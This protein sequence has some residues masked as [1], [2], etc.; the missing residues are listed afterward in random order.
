M[1]GRDHADGAIGQ[2]CRAGHQTRVMELG[3]AR[4]RRQEQDDDGDECHRCDDEV[5]VQRRQNTA[6]VEPGEEQDRQHDERRLIEFAR[7]ARKR[8]H[9]GNEIA[10][11]DGVGG[12]QHGV[13][14]HQ[15]ETDVEGHQRPDDVLG[16]GVLTTCRGDSGGHLG[17]DH[18]HTSIKKACK[19]AGDQRGVGAALADCEVPAHV[20]ADE[21]DAHAQRPH[22]GWPENAQQTDLFD[23]CAGSFLCICHCPVL[24]S[25]AVRSLLQARP[26]ARR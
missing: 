12:F 10:E 4:Q 19:P 11:R 1:H 24:R 3:G 15:V 18:G 25:C 13:G 2:R 20:F 9:L 8:G 14:E 22:V 5:E 17:V 21:H 26:R 16:L 6:I 23:L 7:I